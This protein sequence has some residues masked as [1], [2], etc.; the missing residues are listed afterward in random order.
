[1]K[2]LRRGFIFLFVTLILSTTSVFAADKD[3]ENFVKSSFEN[4][5]IHS[6]IKVTQISNE[7]YAVTYSYRENLLGMEHGFYLF[8]SVVDTLKNVGL[9]VQTFAEGNYAYITYS[10]IVDNLP[11]LFDRFSILPYITL[12]SYISEDTKENI[13]VGEFPKNFF[14]EEMKDNEL[15]KDIFNTNYFSFEYKP[16]DQKSF[17]SNAPVKTEDGYYVWFK[18]GEVNPEIN[19]ISAP[20]NNTLILVFKIV[21][22]G[23]AIVLIGGIIFLIVKFIKK[24]I[25]RKR[26]LNPNYDNNGYD[27]YN[28]YSGYNNYSGYDDEYY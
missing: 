20:L 22:G 10:E 3:F 25:E 6:T 15:I 11:A 13:I 16:I 8:P 2:F 21:V 17:T 18:D 23:V 5:Y 14:E 12:S 4:G 26:Y 1:M 9:E 27:N 19:L 7:E 24:K 28:D